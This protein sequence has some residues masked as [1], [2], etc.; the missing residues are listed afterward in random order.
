MGLNA[1]LVRDFTA[2]EAE[3]LSCSG[4]PDDMVRSK[5]RFFGRVIVN[6]RIS[7]TAES[8]RGKRNS[9]LLQTSQGLCVLQKVAFVRASLT[10]MCLFF[11]SRC[12]GKQAFPLVN[13]IMEYVPKATTIVLEPS[14][15]VGNCVSVGNG[16]VR[17]CC[18]QPNTIE[19]D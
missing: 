6:G 1:P 16:R 17:Y 7:Q 18:L 10:V 13:H 12:E 15:I 2:E 8:S 4:Y 19:K 14:D 11:C 9:S 3:L 5:V